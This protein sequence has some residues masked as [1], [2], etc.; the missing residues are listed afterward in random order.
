MTGDLP[1]DALTAYGAAWLETEPGRRMA[2]LEIAWAP[3]AVYSDP[4]DHVTGREAL[5]AHVAAT[6]EM[7]PGGRVEVTSEPV[8]HHDSA[9][10]R[11]TMVDAS[12]S[13]ALTGWDVVQLDDEGR[14]SRL[15]GFF[16]PDTERAA[17]P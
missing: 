15:T 3:D 12:G 13:P 2:L 7:L 9:F 6:Q 17:A 8:R 10:F 5:A 4:V 1:T 16:D 11:W 14:I